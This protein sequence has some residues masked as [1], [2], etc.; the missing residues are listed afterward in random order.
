MPEGED[1]DLVLGERKSV[2]QVIP[3][4]AEKEATGASQPRARGWRADS[5]MRGDEVKG[6]GNLVV[7]GV[8]RRRAVLCPPVQGLED[9]KFCFGA[10]KDRK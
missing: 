7:E 8:G 5:R 2:I 4:L 6:G 9:L 10:D 1:S 3:G